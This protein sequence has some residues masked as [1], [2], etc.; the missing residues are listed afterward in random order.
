VST[1]T[2]KLIAEGKAK[3]YLSSNPSPRLNRP[4]DVGEGNSRGEVMDLIHDQGLDPSEIAR[5]LNRPVSEIGAEL[6]MLILKGE[7]EERGGK[8]FQC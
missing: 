2:N 7:I 3:I 5:R 1:G 6:T 8:Y 4:L